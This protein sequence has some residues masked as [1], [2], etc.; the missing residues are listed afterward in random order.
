MN[1]VYLLDCIK[2]NIDLYG[3]KY[4]GKATKNQCENVLNYDS[5]NRLLKPY[6]LIFQT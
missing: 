6:V 4:L 1:T 3:H 5:G 2:M